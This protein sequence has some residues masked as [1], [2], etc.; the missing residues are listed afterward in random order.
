MGCREPGRDRGRRREGKA[1]QLD[2]CLAWR[3]WAAGWRTSST[4]SWKTKMTGGN[5][6]RNRALLAVQKLGK[7]LG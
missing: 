5:P 4:G 2:L 1:E 7:K 3:G 6:G